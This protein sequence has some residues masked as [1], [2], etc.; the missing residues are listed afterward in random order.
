[1]KYIVTYKNA[2]NKII[3][4]SFV[5]RDNAA[6]FTKRLDSRIEVGTCL[7]YI[8]HAMKESDTDAHS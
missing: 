2:D 5:Y 7:G 1:M 3:T 8:M 6:E 4:K